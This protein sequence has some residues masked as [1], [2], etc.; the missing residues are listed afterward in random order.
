[1]VDQAGRRLLPLDGHGQGRDGRFRPHVI[2]HR[3]AGDLPGEPDSQA[4]AI[5][6]R[7]IIVILFSTSGEIRR[8]RATCV[9]APLL[10]R[11]FLTGAAKLVGP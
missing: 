5:A 2:T 6:V 3:P 4:A 9:D 10:A 1:M 7:G 8:I 11:S